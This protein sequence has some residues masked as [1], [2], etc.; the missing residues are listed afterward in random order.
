MSIT[1]NFKAIS[2]CGFAGCEIIVTGEANI[3]MLDVM[4]KLEKRIPQGLN[5][6]ILLLNLINAGNAQPENFKHV[7]YNEKIEHQ[8]QYKTVDLFHDNH[9]IQMIDVVLK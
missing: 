3:G 4:P 1:K 6:S 5:P 2:I 8:D 7:Q 9:S